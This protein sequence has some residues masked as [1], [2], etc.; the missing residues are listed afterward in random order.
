MT[1]DQRAFP[2]TVARVTN[3]LPTAGQNRTL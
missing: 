2:Y 1:G 3:T